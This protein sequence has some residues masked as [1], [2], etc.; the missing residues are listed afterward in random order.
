M[1]LV[2]TVGLVLAIGGPVGGALWWA[3]QKVY[4]AFSKLGDHDRR[5]GAFDKE[6]TEVRATQEQHDERLERT[7]DGVRNIS[8]LADAINNMG[9]RVNSQIEHLA[10]VMGIHNRSNERRFEELNDR[11]SEKRTFKAGD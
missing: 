4:A 3:A 2:A 10:E 6:L 11:L 9:E 5:L 7:E 8:K 1:D